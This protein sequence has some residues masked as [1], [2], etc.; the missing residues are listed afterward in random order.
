VS[1][2]PV[3]VAANYCVPLT[4]RLTDEGLIVTE[5]AGNARGAAKTKIAI[6][7]SPP[8]KKR[9]AR[10]LLRV[11]ETMAPQGTETR[12]EFMRASPSA[13]E[14][15]ID[16]WAAPLR[17]KSR[18]YQALGIAA[19]G[20]NPDAGNHPPASLLVPRELDFSSR[21]RFYHPPR[22]SFCDCQVE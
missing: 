3:T 18:I 14:G 12:L 11:S 21:L 20:W 8:A 22:N 16:K 13:T 4:G 2:A 1:L 9:R 17:E 7:S 6:R 5:T 19:S 15:T 10:P